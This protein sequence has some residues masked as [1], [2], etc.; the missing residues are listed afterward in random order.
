M[1]IFDM[2]NWAL[3]SPFVFYEDTFFPLNVSNDFPSPDG[4]GSP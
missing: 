4:S 3:V 1:R 2:L